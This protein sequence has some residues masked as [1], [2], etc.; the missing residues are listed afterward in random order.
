MNKL[1]MMTPFALLVIGC[2]AIGC[3]EIESN[4]D[5]DTISSNGGNA[6][7]T[8]SNGWAAEADSGYS[9]S[10]SNNG[11]DRSNSQYVADDD[12]G[13]AGD[14][15]TEWVENDW[16][17]PAT[18]PTS[19][20]SI[21]VDNASYTWAR[22]QLNEGRLPDPDSVRVEEFVNF[23]DFAYAEPEVDEPFAIDLEVAPSH[24]GPAN[25]QLL[26]IGVKARDVSLAEMKT[27]NVVLL[28][29]TSG[30]MSSN[31]KLA[32]VKESLSALLDNLRPTD[33]I[34][35]VTYAGSDTLAL[36]P[37]PVSDRATIEA[38]IDALESGGSTN[39]A[40]GI[41]TAYDLATQHFVEGGNN[42]VI[43]MTDGDFNVG[44]RG[45]ALADYVAAR[46]NEKIALTAVG[47]GTGNFKDAQMEQLA[48]KGNGNYFYC[49]S[50]DEAGRIFGTELPRTLEIVASDVKLQV[51]FDPATVA[52]YRLIGYENRLLANEDFA[53]D[54]VD[55]G[56]VGP[57]Q[58]VTAFYEVV[59]HDGVDA[60]LLA[61]GRAR[62]KQPFGETSELYE[63]TIKLSARTDFEQATAELRLGA[64]IVEF[65]EVLRMSQHVDAARFDEIEMIASSAAYASDAK[66]AELLTL[67]ST[68]EGLWPAP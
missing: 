51:E 8:T 44:L 23:F 21:D 50:L 29:D 33:T 22:R 11:V 7:A 34:G 30:S 68:A 39:G 40:A 66:M 38:A 25:S 20:F 17:D 27:S 32:M 5:D 26:R 36:V 54:T 37:T 24:F 61:Y 14:E 9:N 4:A 41:S 15:F 2:C 45:D 59:L 60:G 19:T 58:R 10:A 64:A 49:D 42:R 18:E 55:A 31:D 63:E 43:I 46:R 16:I 28:L 67:I 52:T 35:I 62:Y 56:D 53:N 12:P 65:A 6:N 57:G 48:Q 47:Y 3:G 13:Q 1:R